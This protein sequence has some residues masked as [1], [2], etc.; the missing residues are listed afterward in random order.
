MDILAKGLSVG[1]AQPKSNEIDE[2]EPP[3]WVLVPEW[4]DLASLLLDA[5]RGA[6]LQLGQ[7]PATRVEIRGPAQHE[8]RLVYDPGTTAK[9]QVEVR[10]DRYV[11]VCR[12]S[13]RQKLLEMPANAGRQFGRAIEWTREVEE[14]NQLC[15]S[16]AGPNVG[17][18]RSRFL[19]MGMVV[20]SNPRGLP[21]EDSC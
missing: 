9:Q 15:A 20:S 18:I 7:Q 12:Q 14:T 3:M 2:H 17:R 6:L 5:D 1:L 21:L 13:S 10:R 11:D 19:M 4:L 16:K 8:Q